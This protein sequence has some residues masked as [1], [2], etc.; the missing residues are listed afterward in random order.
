MGIAYEDR[1]NT[2]YLWRRNT[3]VFLPHFHDSAEI[4][5]MLS[6]RVRAVIGGEEY[7]LC[8][9]DFSIALPNVIHSYS[10][11][12]S[13]DAYLLIVP[14][15]YLAAY[16]P[17]IRTHSPRAAA[18][19]PTDGCVLTGLVETI[20]ACNKTKHPYQRQMLAGYFSVFFGELFARTGMEENKRTPPET[21]RRI[22][23]YCLEHYRSEISLDLLTTELNVSRNH[24]S[25]IFSQKLKISLPDFLGSLRIAEAKRLIE[26]GRSMTDAAM[27]AGF[28]SIR[29]FNRRFLAETGKTPRAYAQGVPKNGD[30]PDI[31]TWDQR[32]HARP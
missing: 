24:I 8:A 3:L 23:A 16:D 27:E 26:E 21:E 12:N 31:N 4:V 20:I 6:G 2:L 13:V 15:R 17:L 30:D 1:V 10:D 29:T 5:C 25:Y 22:I 9:G 28:S 19:H 18:V 14:R 32:L 11:E 7:E